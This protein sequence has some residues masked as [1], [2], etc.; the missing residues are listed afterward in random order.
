MCNLNPLL[1]RKRWELGVPFQSYGGMLGMEFM[2]RVVLAFT[3][4]FNVIFSFI[5]CIGVTQL[6]FQDF[7]QRKL[8]CV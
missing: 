2:V 5:H 1:F 4:Y 3:T 7:S 8:F 6:E